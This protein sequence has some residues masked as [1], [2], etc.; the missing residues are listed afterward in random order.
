MSDL[1]PVTQRLTSSAANYPPTTTAVRA[2]DQAT[3]R[4]ADYSRLTEA[5]LSLV[6]KL[7]EDGLSQ[8]QI[9]QRLDCSQATISRTLAVFTDTRPL[10]RRYKDGSAYRRMKVLCDTKHAPTLLE[11][12]RDEEVSVKQAPVGAGK[13]GVT[14]VI[15][16]V[17][18]QV[19]INIIELSPP[20]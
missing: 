15:G 8:T 12:A 16:A 5:E 4:I 17:D 3:E 14:V 2:S 18:A 6:L 11:M 9:A 7:N 10:A 1:E 19:Q 13:G 20:E